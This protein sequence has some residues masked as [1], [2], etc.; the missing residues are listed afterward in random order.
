M[1]EKELTTPQIRKLIKAHNVLMSIKI[2]VG[3]SRQQILKIL[4][5]KG[6]MVNH[7][8]KSIQRRYKNERKP[9]VTLTQADK[10]LKKPEKTALQKQ[11]AVEAKEKKEE[12]QKKK[13]RE[14]KKEAVKKAMINKPD[15][16]KPVKK[17]PVKK[18]PMKKEDEVRKARQP[19]P[20]IPPNVKGKRIPKGQLLLED[21][22]KVKDPEAQKKAL[23]RKKAREDKKK[24]SKPSMKDKLIAKDKKAIS[25]EK[26]A[27][28][29]RK[30]D[31]K[32]YKPIADSDL[33]EQM[34]KLN[35]YFVEDKNKIG[36]TFKTLKEVDS[37]IGKLFTVVA[38]SARGEDPF[39]GLDSSERKYFIKLMNNMLRFS[40]TE[41]T[42][43]EVKPRALKKY[44][45][46]YSETAASEGRE[47][48]RKKEAAPAQ[49]QKKLLK[50]GS[51]LEDKPAIRAREKADKEKKKAKEKV[52]EEKVKVKEEKVKVKAKKPV[53]KDVVIFDYEVVSGH[54]DALKKA[55]QQTYDLANSI[56]NQ[57]KKLPPKDFVENTQKGSYARKFTLFDDDLDDDDLD[58]YNDIYSDLDNEIDTQ[59]SEIRDEN[60]KEI[61]WKKP[62]PPLKPMQTKYIEAM[63]KYKENNQPADYQAA[64][65]QKDSI[66]KHYKESDVPNV[67]R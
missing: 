27:I 15:V 21:K 2:P 47:A 57:V 61:N 40:T 12:I 31:K 60:R 67:P 49:L 17:P 11:K 45:G 43:V 46:W 32:P 24:P 20:T 26:K 62:P 52:K 18:P 14:I 34:F 50:A 64:K 56:M 1:A 16:K 66:L 30:D 28:Q 41:K 3:S 55:I 29:R 33:K 4:D 54:S 25:D 5:D 36:K 63:K 48:E 58:K 53:V 35:N 22:K 10:I 42:G 19:Y 39:E 23:A 59:L 8:R 51:Q 7:I 37:A 44:K 65:R 13:E 9:N 6:Y 38:G